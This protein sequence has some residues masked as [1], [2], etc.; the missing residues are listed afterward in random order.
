MRDALRH[1]GKT[2]AVVHMVVYTVVRYMW[3][4]SAEIGA[5]LADLQG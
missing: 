1:L 4:S 2:S 5:K 3:L